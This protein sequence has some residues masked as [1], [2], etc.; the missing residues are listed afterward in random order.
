MT[1]ILYQER[2]PAGFISLLAIISFIVMSLSALFSFTYHYRQAQQMVM[3]ELQAKQAFLLAESALLWGETLNWNISATSANKWQCR[4]FSAETNIKSCFLFMD[5]N[6]SLLQGQSESKNGYKIYHYQWVS[7]LDNSRGV[8]TA[9][10]NGWLDYCPLKN[11]E[12]AL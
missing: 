2:E 1:D 11:K 8:I 9:Y 6:V 5:K 12:C 3:Q 4:T 10:R 7:I